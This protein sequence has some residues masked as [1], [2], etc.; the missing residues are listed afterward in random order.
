MKER[1]SFTT[2]ID[3]A[4]WKRFKLKCVERDEKMNDVLEEFMLSY[5]NMAE[6]KPE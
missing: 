1:K 4:L 6:K 5:V 3:T 2:T